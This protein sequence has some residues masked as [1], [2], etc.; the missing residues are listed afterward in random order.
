MSYVVLCNIGLDSLSKINIESLKVEDLYL[1]IGENLFGFYGLLLYE[2]KIL[3]VNNYNNSILIVNIFDFKEE[4]NLYIG[5]YFNDIKVYNDLVYVVCGEFNLL[6]VYDLIN[7]RV[8]FEIFI[9]KFFY[10]ILLFKEE[11]FIFV[12]NMSD[13][14]IIVIDILK[15]IIIKKIKVESIFI[16]IIILKSK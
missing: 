3:V 14:S 16:K 9:G 15:N 4:K 6:I 10:N 13:D 5:V 8:N 11:N 2:D 1:F 7:E 12:S